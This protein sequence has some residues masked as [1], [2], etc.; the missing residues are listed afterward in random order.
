MK[1]IL[2]IL[3]FLLMGA[4]FIV[5]NGDLALK[6]ADKMER[7][8]GLYYDWLTNLF[9]NGKQ[10]TGYVVDSEWLPETASNYKK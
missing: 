1:I 2:V 7:F 10:I 3:I 9:D 5:G 4:F 6:D 8:R